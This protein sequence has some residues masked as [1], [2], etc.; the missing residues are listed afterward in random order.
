MKAQGVH[1]TRWRRAVQIAIVLFYVALP[2]A[3][4]RGFIAISG[5][6]AALRVGRVDLIEPAAG[7]SAILA[8][9]HVT[10]ALLAGILPVVV[11]ALVLGPV[12]CSWICPWGLVSEFAAK[13]RRGR[14]WS[15]RPWV[16][17]RR[18]RLVSL[19]VW[20][21]ASALVAVPLAALFSPP[22][23]ITALPL[24]FIFLR[25]VSPVTVGGLL[26][27]LVLEIAGPTRIWCRALCPVGAMANYVRSKASLRMILV[28]QGQ[29]ACAAEPRCSAE[30]SWRLDP[31]LIARFD[32][33]TNCMRCIEVCPTGALKPGFHREF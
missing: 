8:G 22:R 6:L 33:C 19:V 14:A 13:L 21:A 18:V 11:L 29:C 12:F 1:W 25:V 7:F 27:L 16:R 31:R 17:L 26:V 9:R 23:L 32:G 30:C 20:F 2:L 3:N 15:G 24:E 10:V 4:A 28:A 5:T